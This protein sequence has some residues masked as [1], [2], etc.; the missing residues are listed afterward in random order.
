MKGD[1]RQPCGTSGA[2]KR[3]LR[4]GEVPCTACCDARMDKELAPRRRAVLAEAIYTG[5]PRRGI[6]RGRQAA[7]LRGDL[8]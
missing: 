4:Y 1:P 8:P 3:H 7:L 6:Q 2:Y 5:K